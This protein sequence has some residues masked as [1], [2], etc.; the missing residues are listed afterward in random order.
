MCEMSVKSDRKQTGSR[1]LSPGARRSHCSRYV[2][3]GGK[4]ANYSV[5]LCAG[6]VCE[7]VCV[8]VCECVCMS[9]RG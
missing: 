3:H 2:E 8:S 5:L 4:G 7:C 6:C 1:R 9:V